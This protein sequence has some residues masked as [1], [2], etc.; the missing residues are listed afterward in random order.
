MYKC[1]DFNSGLLV[2]RKL[3]EFIGMIFKELVAVAR[4]YTGREPRIF[5]LIVK[6]PT[7]AKIIKSSQNIND[8]V[9]SQVKTENPVPNLKEHL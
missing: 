4:I 6:Y 7:I 8:E 2:P 3:F 9:N 1:G 5:L